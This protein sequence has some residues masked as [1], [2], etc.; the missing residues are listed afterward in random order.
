MEMRL[1]MAIITLLIS[2]SLH[3][4]EGVPKH[5]QVGFGLYRSAVAYNNVSDDEFSGGAVSASYAV[6]DNVAFRGTLFSLEHDD[7]SEIDSSGYD[8]VIYGGTGLLTNGFKIYGGGGLFKETWEVSGLEESFN[9]FQLNG[10]LGYNWDV[11]AIDLVI[12]I[13]SVSD[14]DDLANQFGSSVD[15]AVSSNLSIALRF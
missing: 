8:L 4:Q 6:N 7:F 1:F 15:A 2:T 14:Y 10:G 13:R 3:S 12:G 9:G 5:W 11:V